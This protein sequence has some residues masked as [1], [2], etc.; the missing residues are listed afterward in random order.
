MKFE[1]NRRYTKDPEKSEYIDLEDLKK[2]AEIL[3]E[4]QIIKSK[5]TIFKD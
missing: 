1:A 4:I 3:I 2:I 5:F